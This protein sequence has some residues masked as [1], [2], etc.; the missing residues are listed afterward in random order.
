[1]ASRA[2]LI[3]KGK[4]Y[5][6]Y[7]VLH[8]GNA[9]S[10]FDESMYI[11]TALAKQLRDMSYRGFD[12]NFVPK[13]GDD[14]CVAPGCPLAVDD[15]RKNYKLRRGFDRGVCN[16]FSP[17]GDS[18]ASC[19]GEKFCIVESQKTVFVFGDKRSNNDII[20]YVVLWFENQANVIINAKECLVFEMNYSKED[21]SVHEYKAMEHFEMLLN[22]ELI[23]P[24]IPISKLN[25]NANNEMTLDALYLAWKIGSKQFSY[26]S[27]VTEADEQAAIIELNALNNYNWR[28]YPGSVSL[29]INHL[30][31][32][33]DRWTYN[34]K[35]YLFSVMK[36]HASKY[37]KVVKNLLRFPYSPYKSDKDMA[38]ARSLIRRITDMGDRKFVSYGDLTEKLKEVNLSGVEFCRVFK[39]IIKIDDKVFEDGEKED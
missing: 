13:E 36:S 23:D 14:I 3:V 31:M 25:I 9:A 7:D 20:K 33:H 17:L 12:Q 35:D 16:V 34:R 22:G 26:G 1:M 15:L 5:F 24:C 30:L 27:D 8:I 32:S 37:S 4:E 2:Y 11:N 39:T 21:Y 19:W 38:M 18:Y 28:E 10:S 29:V 6:G